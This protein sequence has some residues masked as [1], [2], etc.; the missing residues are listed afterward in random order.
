MSELKIDQVYAD[1]LA[2]GTVKPA[3]VVLPDVRFDNLFRQDSDSFP[4]A[5]YLTLIAEETFEVVSK[6][7]R[8]PLSREKWSI[9]GFSW[10]G[11]IYR[12]TWLADIRVVSEV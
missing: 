1:M 2:K 8:I 10:G 3:L 7:Y 12:S 4:F 9:G 5:N 6:Q 11:G